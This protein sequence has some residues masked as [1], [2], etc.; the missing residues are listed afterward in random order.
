MIACSGTSVCEYKRRLCSR[1][2]GH[3]SARK[4]GDDED[5]EKKGSPLKMPFGLLSKEL[6]LS[7]DVEESRVA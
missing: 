1:Y 7:I 4:D 2:G 3:S 5:K 6:W